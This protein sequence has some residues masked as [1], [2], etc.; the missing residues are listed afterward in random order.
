MSKKLTFEDLQRDPFHAQLIKAVEKTSGSPLPDEVKE[1]M[2]DEAGWADIIPRQIG[3]WAKDLNR[4]SEMISGGKEA[5]SDFGLFWIRLYGL[6]IEIRQYFALGT[7]V[8]ENRS[9][10]I[11]HELIENIFSKF[12]EDE[13]LWIEH[14]R[15]CHCHVN[16]GYNRKSLI[17]GKD[18][19]FKVK[20]SYSGLPIDELNKKLKSVIQPHSGNS[21]PLAKTLSDRIRPEL[22]SLNQ[23]MQT[24]VSTF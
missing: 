24:W 7:L 6:L 19:K 2:I 20:D 5:P 22:V 17:K 8:I 16:Q 1:W 11:I 12:S 4:V 14:E 15:M 3:E 10:K 21:R 18:G 23:I 9:G 13:F